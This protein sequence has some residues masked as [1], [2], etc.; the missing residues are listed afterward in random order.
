MKINLK[1]LKRT[2]KVYYYN[3]DGVLDKKVTSKYRIATNLMVSVFMIAG[4]GGVSNAALN[5]VYESKQESSVQ[6]QTVAVDTTK[7]A[8]EQDKLKN[9]EKKARED[10]ELAK[11]LKSKLKNIP[12][13]QKWS[14]YVRD[15]NS[16]RMANVNSDNVLDAAG[17]DNLL[18]TAPL[19]ARQPDNT[20]NYRAGKSTIV[21]CVTEMIRSN[22]ETC[23]QSINKYANLKKANEVLNGHGLK[24]TSLTPK[25]SKTT[26]RE[27]GELLYRLQNGQVLGD[28]ARR[29]VFDG[30]YSHNMREGIPSVCGNDCLVA[31]IT[32]EAD[33]IKHEAAIV[34]TGSSKY[35]VVVM[36]QGA[37]WSQIADFTSFVR[38]EVQ[39]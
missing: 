15:V 9:V 28:K 21:K 18:V 10:E 35:V 25:E 23:K 6:R 36:T 19:E 1:S 13:G 11:N 24:K 27:I 2:K 14:V 31:N 37:S 29:A 8:E 34:T 30:L 16:D 4:V 12:G 32:G 39:P 26:A 38:S 17:F 7:K 20:W 22:E 33:G 3:R 5:H